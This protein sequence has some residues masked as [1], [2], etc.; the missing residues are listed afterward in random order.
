MWLLRQQ[1]AQ[2]VILYTKENGRTRKKK[3]DHNAYIRRKWKENIHIDQNMLS[4]QDYGP[5]THTHDLLAQ[6]GYIN[7]LNEFAIIHLAIC[8]LPKRFVCLNWERDVHRILYILYGCVCWFCIW[9][10]IWMLYDADDRNRYKFL[11]K[12]FY[13][14][15]FV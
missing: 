1:A 14:N 3:K 15:E 6:R 12:Y 13:L 5:N 10:Y 8:Y 2:P 11:L 7:L 9:N 4:Y